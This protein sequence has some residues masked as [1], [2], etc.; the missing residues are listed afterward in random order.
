ML[1]YQLEEALALL[2][3]EQKRHLKSYDRVVFNVRNATKSAHHMNFLC[4]NQ[5][6]KSMNQKK[7]NFRITALP[8]SKK[9]QHV[10]HATLK[11]QLDIV[12]HAMNLI[13]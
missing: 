12:Y 7:L 11:Y 1:L 5:K 9:S 13:V 8:V 2:A 10:Q 3:L 6:K 4:T